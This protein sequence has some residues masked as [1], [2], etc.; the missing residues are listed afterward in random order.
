[1]SV[2]RRFAF[3]AIEAHLGPASTATIAMR[4]GVSAR[5]V[6][7]WRASGLTELQ[8]DRVAVAAGL[9]PGSVWDTWWS[10]AA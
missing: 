2:D 8:A 7:R 4:L 3:D 5:T 6:W 10:T 1:M 9:H